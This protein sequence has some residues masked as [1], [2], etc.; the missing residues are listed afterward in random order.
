MN[1]LVEVN[2]FPNLGYL[3]Y[4]FTSEELAPIRQEISKIRNNFS[5]SIPHNKDL[6]G[7][8]QNEFKLVDSVDYV[9]RLMLPLVATFDEQFGGYVTQALMAYGSDSRKKE[10]RIQN[11]W[12]NFQEKHEFNPIHSHLGILSFVI[13]LDI[14]YEINKELEASPGNKSNHNLAGHFNFHIINTLGEIKTLSIPADSSYQNQAIIFPA[15]MRH[16][17][18]PFYSS[19]GYRVSLAGNF[20][21]AMI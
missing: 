14:P 18:S 15:V 6:A 4:K 17:V 20:E 11:V 10:V 19:D 21:I 13:W 2:N 1:N 8:I 7:Q 5:S 9:A 16:S 3:K 12:V